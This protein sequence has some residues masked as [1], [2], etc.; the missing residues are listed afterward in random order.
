[1]PPKTK[2][3][4]KTQVEPKTTVK[5][6]AESKIKGLLKNLAEAKDRHE[7]CRLRGHLRKLG[8]RGGLRSRTWTDQSGKT[9][10]I[11]KAKSA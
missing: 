10:I 11:E 1:M 7:K 4:S 6:D 3:K 2:S 8:H 9:H 5:D